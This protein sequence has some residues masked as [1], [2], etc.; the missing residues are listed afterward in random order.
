[1]KL[2]GK[3]KKQF[4]YQSDSQLV[5]ALVACQQDA[6]DY[7]FDRYHELLQNNI[8]S[9]FHIKEKDKIERLFKKRC[10]ELQDYFLANDCAKLK[11]FAQSNSTFDAW[12]V[13][14]SFSF[15]KKLFC[16]ENNALVE[17]YQNGD[18]AIVFERF[19]LDF[20]KLV[21]I[22]GEQRSGVIME[23]AKD[24]AY[25]LREHLFQE[26]W[27][28][29]NTYD[30]A[31]KPFDT[32]FKSVMH[33]FVIDYYKKNNKFEKHVIEKGG[34]FRI[35]EQDASPNWEQLI[36]T[37]DDEEKIELLNLVRKTVETLQPP[38]YRDILIDRFYKGEEYVDIAQRYQVT[39]ANAQNIVSRALKRLKEKLE[40]NGYRNKRK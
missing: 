23:D 15:F 40:E 10:G 35:D 4:V 26:N 3:N 33:N 27:T 30:P 39:I 1:M 18:E 12:L 16:D 5:E 13:V 14:T 19:R 9:A 29:L 36:F 17:R 31:R 38:R 8:K 28:R 25:E 22:N 21:K 34:F 20:E 37:I 2:F 7:V 32:W 24:L 6:F 11:L